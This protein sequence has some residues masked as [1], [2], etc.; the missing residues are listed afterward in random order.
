[1]FTEEEIQFMHD[2]GLHYDFAELSDD[3]WIHIEETVGD[4]LQYDGFDADYNPTQIGL[5]CESILGKLP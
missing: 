4:R 5:I 3:E 2:L 1:M